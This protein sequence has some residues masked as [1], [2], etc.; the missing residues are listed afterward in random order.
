MWSNVCGA[1][2]PTFFAKSRDR[3]KNRTSTAIRSARS[4]LRADHGA[5]GALLELAW[6]L[7]LELNLDASASG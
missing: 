7:F 1:F 6:R 5:S 4:K 2:L 3:R